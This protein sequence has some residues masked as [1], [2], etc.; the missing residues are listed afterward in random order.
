MFGGI[1]VG[2]NFWSVFACSQHQTDKFE[3]QM[4]MCRPKELD[5]S[6]VYPV[7]LSLVQ[8]ST[9]NSPRASYLFPLLFLLLTYPKPG[10]LYVW[11]VA[12]ETE[13][14]R[15]DGERKANTSYKSKLH[16]PQQITSTQ[17]GYRERAKRR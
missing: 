15:T 4:S 16:K 10:S 1:K 17:E 12:M 3:M 2:K 11:V 7:V 6:Q 9:A 14:K 8:F 5:S 13:S